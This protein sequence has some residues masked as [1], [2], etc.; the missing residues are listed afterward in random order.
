MIANLENLKKKNLQR[1]DRRQYGLG[2]VHWPLFDMHLKRVNKRALRAGDQSEGLARA[3]RR[4]C[5][6]RSS[7][8]GGPG[9]RCR[10]LLIR[11]RRCCRCHCLL[12]IVALDALAVA[13][14]GRRPTVNRHFCWLWL[15]LGLTG[16]RFRRRG[17]LLL[18]L[19]FLARLAATVLLMIRDTGGLDFALIF[20]LA[21]R[22]RF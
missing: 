4:R 11:Y 13:T 2:H 22:M 12:V 16:W 18:L 14:S 19:R 10:A 8:L 17:L 7:G 1:T 9:L 20:K 21:I 5:S 15:L 6:R 3:R